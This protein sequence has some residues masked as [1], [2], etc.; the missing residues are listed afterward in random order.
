VRRHPA[1]DL[2]TIAEHLGTSVPAASELVNRLVRQG[3]VTRRPD[4]RERRRIC[5]TL[6]DDGTAQLELAE[7][8]TVDWLEQTLSALE[9]GRLESLVAALGD[10]RRLVGEAADGDERDPAPAAGGRRASTGRR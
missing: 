7:R 4:E 5:L 8:E 10:L 2:S 6:S 3:L 1:T 9:P